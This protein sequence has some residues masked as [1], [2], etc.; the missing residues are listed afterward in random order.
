MPCDGSCANGFAAAESASVPAPLEPATEIQE[1]PP[2]RNRG[3]RRNGSPRGK[4]GR[5]PRG[6]GG[7]VH[8]RRREAHAP[9]R[10]VAHESAQAVRPGRKAQLSV[11]PHAARL[12]ALAILLQVRPDRPREEVLE[13][14]LAVD[15]VG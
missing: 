7:H 14:S 5:L 12:E 2:P 4:E 1:G 13:P 11:I 15:R 10:G 8:G 9:R 3:G 6:G